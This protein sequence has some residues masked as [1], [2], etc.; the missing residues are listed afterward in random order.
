[1]SMAAESASLLRRLR[2]LSPLS[3]MTGSEFIPRLDQLTT[4]L[5]NVIEQC[6]TVSLTSGRGLE[7]LCD[8]LS[9]N[10]QQYL[11]QVSVG[12]ANLGG[13]GS[14]LSQF[15]KLVGDP[16]FSES[17]PVSL[18]TDFLRELV[19]LV[20]TSC[21]HNRECSIVTPLTLP[22]NPPPP[23]HTHIHVVL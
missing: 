18:F 2:E 23:P 11:P 20:N 13:E 19:S 12:V 17:E 15:N 8:Q 9:S 3:P 6:S 14:L 16:L 22:I 1:M 10:Q 5:L 4:A 21:T 7:M